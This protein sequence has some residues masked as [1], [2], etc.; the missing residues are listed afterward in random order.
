[1]KP[2]NNNP[3]DGSTLFIALFL[4]F[5]IFLLSQ[6]SAETR[7]SANGKLF[8]QPRFWPAVGITGMAL[9]GLT[10]L[11]NRSHWQF[12]NSIKEITVWLRS[13]EYLLWF[14]AYVFI[15]PV[16]GYLLSTVLFTTALS[17]RQGYRRA[18]QLAI[19]AASGLL[20]VLVFKIFL[21]VKIPG[22]AIYEYLPG[23]LRNFMITYF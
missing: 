1:M 13:V 22:G 23:A 10:H 12:H 2:Q 14:M 6:I 4:L 3:R 5:V 9:F 17:Y 19:S 18:R 8:A 21:A 11:L 15:V 20:I 16:I 7:Y